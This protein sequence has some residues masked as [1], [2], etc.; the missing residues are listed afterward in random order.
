MGKQENQTDMKM[1]SRLVFLLRV[2]RIERNWREMWNEDVLEKH[3]DY[4]DCHHRK[5][6]T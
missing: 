1:G 3:D 5:Y 4:S 6:I 2:Q